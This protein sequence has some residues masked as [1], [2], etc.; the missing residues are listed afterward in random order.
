[1]VDLDREE[2]FRLLGRGMVG[3]VAFTDRAMPAVQPVTYLL[4]GEEIVFRIGGGSPLA[5]SVRHTVV[6]FQVDEIDTECRSGWTVCGIGET[7][8]VV[9][10]ARL[11]ALAG[12]RLDWWVTG[13]DSRVISVRLRLVTGRRLGGSA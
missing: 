8:H 11:A 13:S 5:A 12:R 3:R 2:C 1:L 7:S 9:D 4:A 10:P 6:A